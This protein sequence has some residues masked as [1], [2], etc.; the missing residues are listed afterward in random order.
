MLG[1]DFH[2]LI[3]AGFHQPPVLDAVGKLGKRIAELEAAI[4]NAQ[5][6]LLTKGDMG[7][8]HASVILSRALENKET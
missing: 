8:V 3:P 4:N 5:L 1:I 7:P 6:A 2:K